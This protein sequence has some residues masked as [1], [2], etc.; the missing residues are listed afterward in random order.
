MF[1]LTKT[2]KLLVRQFTLMMFLLIHVFLLEVMYLSITASMLLAMFL[3][4]ETSKY[5][6]NQFSIVMFL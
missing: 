3:S 4:T 5:L 1:L 6:D 2:Y